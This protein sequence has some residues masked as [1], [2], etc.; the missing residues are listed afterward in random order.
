MNI[1]SQAS[2]GIGAALTC[3][4]DATLGTFTIPQSLLSALPAS[5]STADGTPQ[6]SFSITEQFIGS[7][8]NKTLDLAQTQFDDTVDK[9]P[10]RV[11]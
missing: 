5:Y 2:L 8:T 6:S 1:Q 4:A 3:V 9:A 11:Q 7:F 10:V